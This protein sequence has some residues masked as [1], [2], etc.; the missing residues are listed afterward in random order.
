MPLPEWILEKPEL[1]TGLELYYRAFWDLMAD[2]LSGMGGL[3]MIKWTA[4]REYA[5]AY[6]I[7]DLDEFVRF[8]LIVTSIDMTYLEYTRSKDKK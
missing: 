8:K 5:T 1:H 2:R 6:G 3:G 7:L 4:M